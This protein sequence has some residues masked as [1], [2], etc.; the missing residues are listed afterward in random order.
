MLHLVFTILRLINN[1]KVLVNNAN[2][3]VKICLAWHDQGLC[4][5]RL[6][7][8]FK[9]YMWLRTSLSTQTSAVALLFFLSTKLCFQA[10]NNTLAF[11]SQILWL[12]LITLS[13]VTP[14]TA[15]SLFCFA[16]SLLSY[17]SFSF[18][19]PRLQASMTL[20]ESCSHGV[21]KTNVQIMR[22]LVNQREPRQ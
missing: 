13:L 12:E 1:I 22:E 6:Q 11:L 2:W 17:L 4:C 9:V 5:N 19:L 20:W 14:R 7:C 15:F 18:L 8:C 3:E 10:V 21:Q 16:S